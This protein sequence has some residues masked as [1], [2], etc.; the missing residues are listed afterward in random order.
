MDQSMAALR[1]LRSVSPSISLVRAD[2]MRLPVAAKAFG[3]V[4]MSHLYGLL[5][6]DERV[7]LVNEASRVGH[8]I[9]ILDSGRPPGVLAEQWQARTL[10]D[11]TEYPIFRRH[12]DVETL[13]SEVGGEALFDGQYYVMIR[14]LLEHP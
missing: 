11:G 14:R 5:L 9:V 2:A 3:R 10:P 1:S 7:A 12:L 8:E 6:P 4:F 13:I